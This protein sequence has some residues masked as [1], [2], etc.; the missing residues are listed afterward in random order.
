MLRVLKVSR[1]AFLGPLLAMTC[2]IT[3]CGSTNSSSAASS[4]GTAASTSKAANAAALRRSA[5]AQA[6]IAQ[7]ALDH[8]T[9]KASSLPSSLGSN[10]KVKPG[11]GDTAAFLQWFQPVSGTMISGKYLYEWANWAVYYDKL[12][13][14]VC[15][16]ET[17]SQL[18][19]SLFPGWPS[20]WNS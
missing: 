17:A 3:A 1:L 13:A 7:C 16:T 10:G 5:E 2:A 9:V 19:N 8:G 15:G 14:E 20:V 4:A 18:A 6:M 12:P 11:I